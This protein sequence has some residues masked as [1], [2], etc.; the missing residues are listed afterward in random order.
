MSYPPPDERAGT[1]E[2]SSVI[3]KDRAYWYA[4]GFVSGNPAIGGLLMSHFDTGD[5]PPGA[6]PADQKDALNVLC[7]KFADV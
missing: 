3:D 7:L 5:F 6:N 1:D 2:P 4:L